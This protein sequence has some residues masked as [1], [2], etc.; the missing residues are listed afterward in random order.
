MVRRTWWERSA[1]PPSYRL[2]PRDMDIIRAVFQHRFLRPAHI[3]ALLGGSEQHLKRRLR[4]LWQDRY[5]ERPRSL[6]PLKVLTEEIVYGLGKKGAQ[7]LQ[8]LK[9]ELRVAELD[10]T[11]TP[12]KQVGL[13]YIDHQLGIA[14]FFVALR[15]A[16]QEAG[17]G[18]KW[19]GHFKRRRHR[20]AVP[21]TR[22]V[23]LP[24]G[25]FVLEFP[26]RGA[27]HH[28]LEFDRGNVSLERMRE[29]Y[30]GYFR[31]RKE[32]DRAPLLRRGKHWD[33]NIP[34]FRVITVTNDEDYLQSL[35][36][37]AREIGRNRAHRRSWRA[38]MF[39]HLG[40][41]DLEEPAKLLSPIFRY[42]DSAEPVSLVPG[43]ALQAASVS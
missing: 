18:F 14:T 15:V 29:R 35:R 10:W 23:L 37:I 11:E 1:T 7:L 3:H 41:F 26:G 24:D 19:G 25:Y 16:C 20:L 39:T 40:A 42:A 33:H 12:K 22:Q 27:I 17:I 21:G 38:L 36:R 5:L 8:H 34:H 30:E 6:R 13:P 32:K 28:F 9:P 43:R 4:F 2:Q 31:V